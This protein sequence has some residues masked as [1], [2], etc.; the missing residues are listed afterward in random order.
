MS[1]PLTQNKTANENYKVDELLENRLQKSKELY[2]ENQ[3]HQFNKLK[4]EIEIQG[5]KIMELESHN[6]KVQDENV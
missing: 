5:R 6:I 1:K 4:Y 2:I 3:M